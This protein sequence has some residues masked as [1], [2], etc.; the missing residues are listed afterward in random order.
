LEKALAGPSVV[1]EIFG[2]PITET[3]VSTWIIMA[4]IIV[5]AFLLTRRFEQLPRGVQNVAEAM[6]EGINDFTAQT[7]GERNRWFAPY[8]GT[9]LIFIFLAN[10]SGLFTLWPPTADAATTIGL[11][12]ITFVLILY[13]NIK[14][15]GL[16]GY[17]KGLFW[18]PIP[19]IFA[20]INIIGELATPVSLAFRLYGNILAGVVIMGLV[21]SAMPI[22]I[23]VPLHFYFDL[24]AGVLQ[25]FIFT[26]LTMVFVSMAMDT[27]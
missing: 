11:A 25:S 16:F 14:Y 2:I 1:F 12:L 27:D 15:K 20:P 7:M 26:M 10:I 17:L 3:V 18:E 21:Y 19:I 24:F 6:V 5:G 13:S 4:V 9:I 23:P 22:L 8:A